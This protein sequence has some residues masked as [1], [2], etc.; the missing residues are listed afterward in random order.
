MLRAWDDERH[1]RELDAWIT[2]D[3]EPDRAA[4]HTAYR[5][6][7]FGGRREVINEE[8]EGAKTESSASSNYTGSDNEAQESSSSESELEDESV[9][10]FRRGFFVANERADKNHKFRRAVSAV[11]AGLRAQK[12]IDRL[13]V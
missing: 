1:E 3:E 13:G 9:Q 6:P 12:R 8:A 2:F 7:D 10:S 4:D 11:M 5:D